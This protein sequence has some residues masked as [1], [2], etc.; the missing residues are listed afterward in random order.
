LEGGGGVGSGIGLDSVVF[1]ETRG[2][3]IGIQIGRRVDEIDKIE[4]SVGGKVERGE[5]LMR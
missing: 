3:V 5:E 1:L 4:R 2:I